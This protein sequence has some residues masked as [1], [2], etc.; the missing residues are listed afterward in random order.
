MKD[1]PTIEA[2]DVKKLAVS[3][4]CSFRRLER[5]EIEDVHRG[6]ALPPMHGKKIP[7]SQRT[8]IISVF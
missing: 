7:N 1:L 5:T 2:L 8:P 3:D 4:V 6:V